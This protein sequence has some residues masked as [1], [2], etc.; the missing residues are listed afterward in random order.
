M[1]GKRGIMKTTIIISKP[2]GGKSRPFFSVPFEGHH[3]DSVDVR[4]VYTTLCNAY[5]D[6]FYKIEVELTDETTTIVDMEG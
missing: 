2:T 5:S 1:A 4:Q 3:T 6:P